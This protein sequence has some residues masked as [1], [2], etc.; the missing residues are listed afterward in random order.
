M[1]VVILVKEKTNGKKYNI[2]FR[3]I[4]DF[5]VFIK[6]PMCVLLCVLK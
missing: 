3:L 4:S 5:I 6:N 1:R 2:T